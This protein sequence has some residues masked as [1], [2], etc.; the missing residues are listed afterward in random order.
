MPKED[1]PV[2]ELMP[3]SNGLQALA[4]SRR[5]WASIEVPYALGLMRQILDEAPVMAQGLGY[6][7]VDTFLKNELEMDPQ[8][9]RAVVTASSR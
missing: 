6:D 8:Q 1:Q 2:S 7:S 9:L 4:R 3:Y 5:I